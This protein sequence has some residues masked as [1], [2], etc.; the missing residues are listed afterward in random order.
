MRRWRPFLV[1]AGG[2]LVAALCAWAL[3]P[4]AHAAPEPVSRAGEDAARE[5]ADRA[6]T[7]VIILKTRR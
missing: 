2:S 3:L 6:R 5:A 4:T 1:M 7:K